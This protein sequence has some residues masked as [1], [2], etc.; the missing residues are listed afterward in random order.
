MHIWGGDVSNSV[1]APKHFLIFAKKNLRVSCPIKV[2]L[3]H[4]FIWQLFLTN[5]YERR[6]VRLKADN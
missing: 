5:Y 1:M 2:S 6:T 3:Y 4:R